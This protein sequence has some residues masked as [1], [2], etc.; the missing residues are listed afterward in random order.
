LARKPKKHA[1]QQ[2]FQEFLIIRLL[3]LCKK[4]EFL[5]T[6]LE[7]DQVPKE[8]QQCSSTIYTHFQTKPVLH[9]QFSPQNAVAVRAFVD[10]LDTYAQEYD[11]EESKDFT[12]Y[13]ISHDQSHQNTAKLGG[14]CPCD[15]AQIRNQ[16]LDN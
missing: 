3:L 8:A 12:A 11:M 1:V 6:P 5:H 7:Q 9:F 10:K 13:P 4:A 16:Y 15:P 2:D 14:S